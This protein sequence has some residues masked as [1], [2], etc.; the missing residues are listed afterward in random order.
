MVRSIVVVSD[1]ALVAEAIQSALRTRGFEPVGADDVAEVGLVICEL[2]TGR[3]VAGTFVPDRVLDRE[4]WQEWEELVAQRDRL[5]EHAAA[6][7]LDHVLAVE[8]V[9]D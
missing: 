7:R 1:R 6:E 2:S 8:P 5:H 9:L 3:L 4:L